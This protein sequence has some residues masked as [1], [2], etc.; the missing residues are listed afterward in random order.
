[1]SN[2]ILAYLDRWVSVVT[3]EMTVCDACMEDVPVNDT[4]ICFGCGDVVCDDCCAFGLCEDCWQETAKLSKSCMR[5]GGS[6]PPKET[7]R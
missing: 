5:A 6:P 3:D 1:M 7:R 2:D 4:R